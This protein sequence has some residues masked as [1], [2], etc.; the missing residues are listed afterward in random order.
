LLRRQAH[1]IFFCFLDLGLYDASATQVVGFAATHL[2]GG[3]WSGDHINARAVY[4]NNNYPANRN[5]NIGFQ[6]VCSVRPTFP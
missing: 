1:E 5:N 4:R 3:S 2:R 6:V